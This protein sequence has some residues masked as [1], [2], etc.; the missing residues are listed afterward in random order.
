[1]RIL[2]IGSGGREHALAWKIAQSPLCERIFVAPGNAG[3]GA[4]AE[5]VSLDARDH[6]AVVTFCRLMGVGLVVIGPEAPLTDGLADALRAAG[7]PAFGPGKEAARL[8]GSKA[9]MKSVCDAAGIPTASYASFDVYG[10]AIAYVKANASYPLVVKADGLAAGKG[11][12]IAGTEQE[13]LDALRAIMAERKFGEEAGRRVVV[14][15]FLEGEEMSFFAL[16]SG[17]VCVPFGA[18]QDHKRVGDGDTGENTGGMGTYAPPPRYDDALKRRVMERIVRPAARFLKEK[19]HVYNGVLFAGLMLTKDGP[20]LLEFNVRFGD[21]ETQVLMAL[22]EGDI[23]PLLLNVAT[24]N[25]R[26]SDEPDMQDGAAVCVVMAAKGYPNDYK[27]GGIVR[28][29]DEAERTEGVTV[30][31]A[32]TVV[33]AAGH[34]LAVGGRVLGVTAFASS[35]KEARERAYRGVSAIAWEDGMYR[36]D[37]ALDRE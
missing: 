30:F 4:L 12:V 24:G 18:A 29:L 17:D 9:F 34:V 36:R 1:M 21:P 19:G 26:E 37:I 13:A 11:V 15:E 3:T 2:I 27:K 31:H 14:E 20:K 7:I 35:I 10:D 23:L 28:N 8:E 22:F 16:V 5:D 33:G 6:E 32:G 25:L